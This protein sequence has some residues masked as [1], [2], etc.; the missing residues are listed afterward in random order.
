M[1]QENNFELML[2][3]Q[4][5]NEIYAAVEILQT[6]LAPHLISLSADARRDMLKKGDKTY[7]FVNKARE[8]AELNP[9]LVPPFLDMRMFEADIRG[10]QILRNIAQHLTP[11]ESNVDDSMMLCGSESYRAALLFYRSVKMAMDT[12]IPNAKSIYE[13]LAIRFPSR[14]RKSKV[15]EE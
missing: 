3:D 2:S 5:L 8:Y 13:D 9:N 12:G 7:A 14:G 10:E 6:K 4:D 1:A 15:V 11:L